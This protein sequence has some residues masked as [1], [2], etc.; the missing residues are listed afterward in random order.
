VQPVADPRFLLDELVAGVDEQLE[1]GVEV[2]VV[3]P[4]QIGLTQ[5]DPRDGDRVALIVLA[6]ATRPAPRLRRQV[7]CH[8]HH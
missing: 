3:H 1:V 2:R 8:I 4:R 7:R 5:R 6:T